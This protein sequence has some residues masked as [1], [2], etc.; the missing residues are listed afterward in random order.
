MYRN[1]LH[2]III[3]SF[4]YSYIIYIYDTVS[5]S[6]STITVFLPPLEK[7]GIF[8]LKPRIKSGTKFWTKK[9]SLFHAVVP[10]W[11]WPLCWNFWRSK[12]YGI[13]GI[14][15]LLGP[16]YQEIFHSVYSIYLVS[17]PFL[18]RI[19]DAMKCAK[20]LQNNATCLGGS[21]GISFRYLSNIS[22]KKLDCRKDGIDLHP[23]IPIQIIMKCPGLSNLIA[24]VGFH[25][26]NLLHHG[27]F[28]EGF[29]HSK[30]PL[31]TYFAMKQVNRFNTL[32]F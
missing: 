13:T 9:M 24:Q 2:K 5:R 17:S 1:G 26:E 22:T 4:N 3:Q 30:M 29:P 27:R 8:Q 25:Y 16:R 20:I 32:N 14:P 7:L 11:L 6:R 21:Q 31:A 15:C 23:R 18:K 28:W 12:K 19:V 10:P